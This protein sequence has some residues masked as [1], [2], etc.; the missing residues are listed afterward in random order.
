TFSVTRETIHVKRHTR[1]DTRAT[2]TIQNR[3]PLMAT[4]LKPPTPLTLSPEPRSVFLAGSIEMGTAAPWQAEVERE[5][6][7][8]D[9]A[10]LNPRRDDWDSSWRQSMDEPRFRR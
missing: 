2:C 4:I 10:V 3:S 1:F 9:L 8:L 7:S 6:A 5:L